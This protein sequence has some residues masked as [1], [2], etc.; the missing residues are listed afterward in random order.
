MPL[1]GQYF[2]RWY[3]IWSFEYLCILHIVLV[4]PCVSIHMFTY[5]ASIFQSPIRMIYFPWCFQF[6]NSLL[7]S[8]Q[9]WVI[10]SFWISMIVRASS[11]CLYATPAL[12]L[13]VGQYVVM[14]IV[15]IFL[16]PQINIHDQ[17]PRFL[18][19]WHVPIVLHDT[20]SIAMIA[21]PPFWNG[22]P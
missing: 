17:W 2:D 19:S 9:N 21:V 22:P 8:I 12:A 18:N 4:I 6:E 5:N 3:V 20:S 11:C 13:A 1:I 7:I 16:F 15:L 10:G 14:V